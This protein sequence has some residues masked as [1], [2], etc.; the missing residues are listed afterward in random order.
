[1]PRVYTVRPGDRRQIGGY[2]E[3]TNETPAVVPQAVA[4]ELA[5]SKV[6]R[7][8]PDTPASVNETVSSEAGIVE[9][10]SEAPKRRRKE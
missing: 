3:A 2:G 4:D 1:M 5:W 9:D 7:V 10:V 8:E 6:L